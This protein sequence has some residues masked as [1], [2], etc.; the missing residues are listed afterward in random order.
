MGSLGLS[1]VETMGKKSVMPQSELWQEYTADDGWLKKIAAECK[2]V[3]M[4][5]CK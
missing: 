1:L 2:E 5:E 3:G 4:G